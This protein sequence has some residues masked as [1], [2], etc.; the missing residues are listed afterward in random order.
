MYCI[1]RLLI[2]IKVLSL[3]FIEGFVSISELLPLRRYVD[4]K[5]QTDSCSRTNS[6]VID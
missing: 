1:L 5:T 3:S 4:I 6:N 2:E